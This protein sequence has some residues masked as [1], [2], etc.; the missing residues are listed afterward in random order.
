M[1]ALTRGT[2]RKTRVHPADDLPPEVYR[3]AVDQADIAISITDPRANILYANAAFTAITGY[4]AEEIVGRNESVLSNH[5]TPARLYQEMWTHL[6]EQRP[7]SGRV[8]N[9]RKDGQLYLADLTISPVVG[10]DGT[11]THFLGI[12]R[13]VTE[14]N[15]LE[16]VV[17]NQ[18]LLIETSLDAAPVALVVLDTHGRVILDNQASKKLVSDVS[19]KEPA[20]FV[21]DMVLPEWRETLAD[22]PARCAFVNREVRIDRRAGQPHWLSVTASVVDMHSDCADSYFCGTRQPALMLVINDVTDLHE[23][24]ERARAA[25]LKLALI[26]E[27]RNAAIREGL[28]AALYR[29]DEPLNMMTSAVHVL[30]RR[31]PGTAT[32]LDEAVRASRAHLEQL[33]QVIPPAPPESPASVNLNEILRDVLEICVPR[34]LAAGITVDWKPTPLLPHMNGRP[35]QLRMLFKALVDNAIEAMNTRGWSRRELSVTSSVTDERVVV[36]VLDTGPGLDEDTR[37]RAFEPFFSAKPG[38]HLGTGL[39]RAQHI[40]ADHGGLID[41]NPRPGG[42]C[43]AIVELRI[44]GDPI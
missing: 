28:S 6:A 36:C 21:L 42:G 40:V 3:Q 34:M 19:A 37:L 33:R 14:L 41:L 10:H 11:T 20:Y 35:L 7:W 17:R 18:K 4:S 39:S 44:D 31:E 8:L 30:Q 9:R 32:V 15:R 29:L 5:T 27:E 23:E 25:A 38:R 1:T 26:D 13:D 24:Q 43:A 16:R 2:S 12:H 22:D